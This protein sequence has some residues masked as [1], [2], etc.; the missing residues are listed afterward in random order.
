MKMKRMPSTILDE[1]YLAQHLQIVKMMMKGKKRTPLIPISLW[2][3]IGTKKTLIELE[4][5]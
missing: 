1:I 2:R 4:K 5:I 3:S